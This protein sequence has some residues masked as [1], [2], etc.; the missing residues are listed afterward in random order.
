[1]NDSIFREITVIG[2]GTMGVG[3]AQVFMLSDAEK[4]NLIDISPET[5][6]R[7]KETL[8]RYFDILQKDQFFYKKG[9]KSRILNKLNTSTELENTINNSDLVLEVVPEDIKL[10]NDLL[11]KIGELSTSQTIIASNTSTFTITELGYASGKP[12][13]TIGM[14]FFVPP[15]NQSCIEVM[16]GKKTSNDTFSKVVE[17]S[18]TIPTRNGNM[19]V[20]PIHKDTPGFISNRILIPGNLYINVLADIALKKGIPYEQLDADAKSI[21]GIGPYELS[22]YLG[23]DTAYN[24]LKSFEERVSHEF[25]PGK[26]LEDLVSKGYYGKKAGRG[27]YQY[28]ENGRAKIDKT[29]KS[30]LLNPELMLA[31]QLN[32]GCKL[33]E[34]KIVENYSIIEKVMKI[35]MGLPGP[36]IPGKRN[37]KKWAKLLNNFANE[38]QI[39]YFQPCELMRSGKFVGMRK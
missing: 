31:I 15:I 38:H 20:A 32:E 9:E 19:F 39:E 5:L 3:I 33:L 1:M 12:R 35:G 4:V 25:A 23:L 14:H 16:R 28:N 24:A 17:F 7:T 2:A 26:V 36:F 6:K 8:I 22:D 18:K 27:F 34:E 37:Y 21:M 29:I 10:K 13:N 11:K 30:G